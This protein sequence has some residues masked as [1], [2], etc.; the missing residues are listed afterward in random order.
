MQIKESKKIYKEAEHYIDVHKHFK[1]GIQCK[2][3]VEFPTEKFVEYQKDLIQEF[4]ANLIDDIDSNDY[5]V[6]Q[7]KSNCE[8]ALQDLNTKLKAFADKVRDVEYF[9][10]KGY[11]QIIIGMVLISSMIGNVNVMIF[12]DQKMYYNLDN[13]AKLRG[14]IDLFSEFI[15]WDLESGDELIYIGTKISDVLD[16]YDI[17]E[18]EDV[19]KTESENTVSFINDILCAR[20]EKSTIGFVTSYYVTGHTAKHSALGVPQIQ[21]RAQKMNI[22]H[23]FKFTI[24]KNKYQI[25]VA[26]LSVF[27]IFMLYSLLSQLFHKPAKEVYVNS[28]W[29]TVDLTI[30]DI[31]KDIAIFKTMDPMWD[32]KSMKYKEILG[33]LNVLEQK[34][35]RVEDIQQLKKLLKADYYRGFNIIPVNN[36]A[37]LDDPVAGKKTGVLTFNTSEKDKIWTLSQIEFGKDIMIAG[38][39]GALI[40]ANND[41]SRWSLVNYSL[42]ES[43]K[44]C[45]MSLSK[46][47]FY[48]F[49]PTGKIYFV[50]RSGIEPVTTSDADGFP[51]DIGGVWTYGKANMYVFSPSVTSLS[52]STLVTRYRNTVGSQTMYQQGQ[53][54]MLAPE[55]ASKAKFGSGFSAF[56]IDVNFLTWSE[57]KL[58]QFRR[59][60]ATAMTLTYREIKLLGGDKMTAAYSNNIKIIS[61]AGSR[62]FYL[63]DKDNQTFTVY[64]SNPLKTN[65]QFATSYNLTYLFR[66]SFDIAGAKMIDVTIPEN[67]ANRPELYLLSTIGVNKI[68]LYEFID[69]LKNNNSLK[70]ITTGN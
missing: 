41:N 17:Q 33:K 45:N 6:D 31:K 34:G 54:Y 9:E 69:S 47:G 39:K 18:L 2:M 21:A 68:N 12:R 56:A 70:Q 8:I 16:P 36:L 57:G 49:T 4:I 32:E 44:G 48:C 37:D 50:G 1:D 51:S 15:E 52:N 30:D 46:N 62:Y 5:D 11:F 20:L 24:F 43:T 3:F 38:D 14:K 35:R 64:D 13:G 10:I 58:Y 27:V 55:L 65:D 25:T 53:K 42:D 60:T 22:F 26:L 61:P 67:L 40:W 63:W 29:V 7:I 19:I 59:S 28:Q 23:D 66:F